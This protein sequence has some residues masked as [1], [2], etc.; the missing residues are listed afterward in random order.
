MPAEWLIRNVSSESGSPVSSS[1]TRSAMDL[2]LG[3]R[4][5]RTPT[6]P[7]WNDASTMTTFLPSSVAAATA[8]LTAT[9]V[10]PTPPLGL[11]T[12]TTRPGSPGSPVRTLPPEPLADATG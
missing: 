11:K 10:R 7:N 1:G 9:V 2:F 6:S 4:L 3:L 5:S 12:A 8:R